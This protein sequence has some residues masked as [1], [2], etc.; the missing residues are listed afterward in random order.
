MDTLAGLKAG[1]LAGSTRLKLACGLSEFPEEIFELADTLEELDLTG[2]QLSRLPEDLGRLKHLRILFCSSNHFTEL[3]ACVGQCPELSMI[4]FKANR[5]VTVNAHSLPPKLRW[6][7]LT[8]N[9]IESL[10]DAPGLYLGLQKLML[11]GN[12]LRALPQSL[13]ECDK[14]ELLRLS[15]NRLEQLP[16]WLWRLPRLTWLAYAGN[17]LTVDYCTPHDSGT[18]ANIPWSALQLRHTL[19]EGASGIIQQARWTERA[20]DVAVKLYKGTM[21]SDGS[22][23]NEMV[24][25][26]AAGEHPNLIKVEGRI[27]DHPLG[28]AGLVMDLI[29]PS[30]LNLAGPPSFASCTRDVYPDDLKI[31]AL[32][33]QRM[34]GGIAAV[35]AQLH[36]RGINHGDLYAHNILWH[37]AGDCLLGDFGAAG[38]YP[39][40]DSDTARALERVEV[41]AFAVLLEELL[42][43]CEDGPAALWTLQRDCIQANV[44]ARPSFNE[45][46]ERITAL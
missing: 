44:M 13:A 33:L 27:S 28:S 38:F 22:P 12:R 24:A 10:P 39:R 15:A 40:D 46:L 26:I 29:D 7:I 31:T 34:I 18:V 6:L 19:G 21:T 37:E 45:I 32:V 43:R 20:M 11:S 17:P 35:A 23:L 5:I 3:P 1:K 42:E 2:N 25:C 41:R 16:D 36:A 9:C 4:G 8:D 30:Y 14:L